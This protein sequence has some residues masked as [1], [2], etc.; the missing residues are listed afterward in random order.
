LIQPTEKVKEPPSL[1][2]TEE[3]DGSVRQTAFTIT[4]VLGAK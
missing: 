2:S 4:Y 1:Y 3:L